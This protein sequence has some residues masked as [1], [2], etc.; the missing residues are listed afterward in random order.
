MAD[1][2][3]AGGGGGGG[4]SGAASDAGTVAADSPA[5]AP[6]PPPEAAAP[7]QPPPLSLG[8]SGAE[9]AAWL[10]ARKV[11]WRELRAKRRRGGGE[12]AADDA[13]VSGGGGG[14]LERRKQQV[15]GGA[16][17]LAAF[18]RPK[19]LAAE[20]TAAGSGASFGASLSGS[21]FLA[22]SARAGLGTAGGGRGYWQVV[23]VREEAPTAAAPGGS[24][25]VFAF[26]SPRRLA[27][28]RLSVDRTLYVNRRVPE[29]EGSALALHGTR[30]SRRLPHDA[31]PACV[32]Q[33]SLPERRFRRL[34]RSID[35]VFQDAD[36]LGVYEAGTPPL[37]RVLLGLGCVARV[38]AGARSR[39]LGRVAA[40]RALGAGGS[41]SGSGGG[42]AT[43]AWSLPARGSA[44]AA[45][46]VR[47]RLAAAIPKA[48]VAARKVQP[49]LGFGG[50]SGGGDPT[51]AAAV[52]GNELPGGPAR[53]PSA[54][55]ADAVT[56]AAAAASDAD[57]DAMGLAVAASAEAGADA[58]APAEPAAH[59]R[60]S[61]DPMLLD[62][63]V[64]A[65]E[66]PEPQPRRRPRGGGD[67]DAA[68]SD[69]NGG[70]SG[71]GGSGSDSSSD[72]AI[73]GR[74]LALSQAGSLEHPASAE[75]LQRERKRVAP[76]RHSAAPGGSAARVFPPIDEEAEATLVLDEDESLALAT[77]PPVYEAAEAT[78]V[79][80]E[81]ECAAAGAADV[82]SAAVP[83]SQGGASAAEGAARAE[84][85]AEVEAELAELLGGGEAG[86]GGAEA[87]PDDAGGG[88]AVVDMSLASSLQ[89]PVLDPSQR[90]P[91]PLGLQNAMDAEGDSAGAGADMNLPP[92]AAAAAAASVAQ[93]PDADDA[94][95]P[96]P[97]HRQSRAKQQRRGAAGAPSRAALRFGDVSAEAGDA[98]LARG[99]PLS[100][101][102]RKA[103]AAAA[104]QA[105]A[106]AA[107]ETAALLEDAWALAVRASRGSG[108]PPEFALSDLELLTTSSC[109]YLEPAS[110]VFRRAFLYHA[111]SSGNSARS[112]G[113][114]GAPP[115]AITALFV[116]EESSTASAE[117]YFSAAAAAL[118]E[119]TGRA[120]L[121]EQELQA[122]RYAAAEGVQGIKTPISVAV[123]VFITAAGAGQP[124]PRGASAAVRAAAAAAANAAAPR[125]ALAATWARVCGAGQ[126]HPDSAPTFSFTALGRQEDV[127]RAV[128]A[129]VAAETP[130]ASPRHAPLVLVTAA[131]AASLPRLALARLIPAA[132]R[133][134][135][136][137]MDD[138]APPGDAAFVGLRW[139]TSLAAHAM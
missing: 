115:R 26:T 74:E 117:A 95:S 2:S 132:A 127:W 33:L 87:R 139:T 98:G 82:A 107:A 99:K 30:V 79:L 47:P 63:P 97:S 73:G 134:P 1:D 114:G 119:E 69:D 50:G 29:P 54:R 75:Q 72:S 20:A 27:I 59:V 86:S 12:A 5:M 16:A 25:T 24:F 81:D 89:L 35:D 57:D 105:A 62:S 3:E 19:P 80:D 125:P 4:G 51:A 6:A 133:V 90:A 56:P 60:P 129:L 53:A 70:G 121:S 138:E 85:D 61:A 131:G 92:A 101:A 15:L 111:S 68:S 65:P 17:G 66:T 31:P 78:L 64:R 94:A 104:Q 41:G 34:L 18:L 14:S 108:G 8:A 116:V 48:A 109:P 42:A 13:A 37:L 137:A 10:S 103:A 88:G 126:L 83:G 22:S 52:G 123:H 7:P 76:A 77:L 39:L 28:F 44:A 135:V 38:D 67:G 9:V 23:E 118:R 106:A 11:A 21:S 110:A 36:V 49:K 128:S 96:P 45:P 93:P 84:R 136:V 55:A 46:R 113:G 124:P 100:A 122:L 58:A 40:E 91:P 130:E 112:S 43:G 102:A 32:Y 120:Q 71:D